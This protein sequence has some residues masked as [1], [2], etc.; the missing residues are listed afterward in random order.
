MSTQPISSPSYQA[1]PPLQIVRT[2]PESD[3]DR[4]SASRPRATASRAANASGGHLVAPGMASYLPLKRCGDLL[5]A[6]VI[7]VL[8]AP[9]VLLAGLLVRLTSRGPAFYRQVRMG[10]DGR[11]FTLLKLRT[12]RQDAEAHSGP[13]W[14]CDHDD[15]I[16]PFGRLLRQ[17]HIDEFPQLLNVIRGEMSLVGPGP[18][19]PE[20][21]AS[22]EL[23]VHAY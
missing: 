12:M 18:G 23:G 13:V 7:L 17:T 14:A 20:F 19:R 3:A 11:L 15:R 2:L 4:L 16:T 10:L 6:I 5:L 1:H 9:V 8:S 21:A 22:G